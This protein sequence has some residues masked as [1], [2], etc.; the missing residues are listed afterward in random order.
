[1]EKIKL[2]NIRIYA[3]HGCMAE[4]AKIGSFYLINLTVWMDLKMAGLSD[5]L[6]DTVNYGDLTNIIKAQMHK[7]SNLLE[8]IAHRILFEIN[9]QFP[10]INKAKISVEKINPPV[11][12]DLD[13]VK[14][15]FKKKFN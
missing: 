6:T 2:K 9:L 5:N 4:E 14:V 11:N 13:T 15:T 12:A 1:M 7:R 8:N 3:N 10:T